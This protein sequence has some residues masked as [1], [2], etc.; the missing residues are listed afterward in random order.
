MHFLN[1]GSGRWVGR[2]L[3]DVM[4]RMLLIIAPGSI[5][6]ADTARESETVRERQ[7]GLPSG[8]LRVLE[9]P[10]L[11]LWHCLLPII[12]PWFGCSY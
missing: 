7:R 1:V 12:T 11:A 5:P 2:F 6:G 4:V 10:W 3:G 8:L 9:E